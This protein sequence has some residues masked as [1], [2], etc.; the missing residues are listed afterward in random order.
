VI[1]RTSLRP[2]SVRFRCAPKA[3]PRSKRI[4]K[5]NQQAQRSDGTIQR[6][7]T[8]VAADERLLVVGLIALRPYRVCE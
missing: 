7:L 3:L 4:S 8:V 2:D 6:C 5:P 1:E